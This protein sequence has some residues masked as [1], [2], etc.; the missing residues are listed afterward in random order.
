MLSD[1]HNE[2]IKREQFYSAMICSVIANTNR[3]KGSRSFKP[4]DFMP[5]EKKIR[6]TWQEQLAFIETLV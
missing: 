6:Q 2:R 1:R 5:A 3:G 4:S